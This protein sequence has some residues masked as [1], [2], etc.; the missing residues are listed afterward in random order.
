MGTGIGAA[1]GENANRFIVDLREYGLNSRL[2]GRMARLLLPALK[3]GAVVGKHELDDAH[4]RLGTWCWARWEQ[5]L[6]NYSNL[7]LADSRKSALDP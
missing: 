7:A 6:R 2:H 4:G 3:L 1:A 5:D